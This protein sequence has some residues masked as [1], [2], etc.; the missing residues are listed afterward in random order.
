M[1]RPKTPSGGHGHF[2]FDNAWF[3]ILA[4]IALVLY[5]AIC[6]YA[7]FRY[8]WKYKIAPRLS[9]AHAFGVAVIVPFFFLGL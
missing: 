2:W 9:K 1:I 5:A 8:H 3:I 4:L 7:E 6:E